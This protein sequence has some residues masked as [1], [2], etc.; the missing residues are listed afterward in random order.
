MKCITVQ[1]KEAYKELMSTGIYKAKRE[2]ISD[3]MRKPY[4]FMQEQFGW[5]STP[6]FLSPIGH[7]IEM[8]GAKFG[9]DAVA[10]EFDIPDELCKVQRYY[11]WSDF[12]YF[13]DCPGEFEDACN[14]DK[15]KTIEEWAK[16]IMNI[17]IADADK[18]KDPVQITVKEL[19]KEWIT[20]VVSDT[21]RLDS[22][23][24][25]SGGAEKLKELKYY[26]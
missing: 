12:V 2:N 13:T 22:S 4:K 5:N 17:N 25:G 1:H 9:T 24:N 20:D 8:G 11:D 18:F 6:I 3:I 10:I 15:Y 23:H 14:V 19:R 21:L 7:Y 16:T 26:K